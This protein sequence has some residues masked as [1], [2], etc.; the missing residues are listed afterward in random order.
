MNASAFLLSDRFKQ[1]SDRDVQDFREVDQFKV[2]N[3]PFAGFYP[4][5]GFLV[6]IE[7]GYLKFSGQLFLRHL[8]GLSQ[9][10]NHGTAL[11]AAGII[12]KI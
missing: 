7:S 4:A 12:K 1:G 11:V 2:R 9:S 5:D 10:S 3:H 6:Q 8:L